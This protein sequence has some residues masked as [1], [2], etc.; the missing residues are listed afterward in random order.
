MRFQPLIVPGWNDSGPSHWQSQ[1]EQTLGHARRVRQQDW[2]HPL[3][4][5]WSAA[6]NEAVEAA[7]C[8]VLLIAHSLGCL[9]AASVP[10]GLQN[11]I[12]GALLVAPPDV[13]RTGLPP[14]IAG[15]A[16][17]PRRPLSFH[18]VVVASDN[19]PYC[20]LARAR[21]FAA[22]WGSQLVVIPDGGHL[23]A[24]SGLGQWPAGL[25]LLTALRR[26]VAWRFNPPGP[27]IAPLTQ[28]SVS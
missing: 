27:R 3:P 10:L 6:V 24:E 7:T 11:K 20:D 22:D 21:T 9:A 14:G 1:W 23:N 4:G 12:A 18:S 8:P 13:E 28:G 2:S 25:K 26:R 19:D 5:P 16:A 17:L 15:F